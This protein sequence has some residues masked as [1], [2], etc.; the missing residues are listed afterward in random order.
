MATQ[1]FTID[2]YLDAL[3]RL[4]EYGGYEAL[5]GGLRE[6]FPSDGSITAFSASPLDGGYDEGFF[7]QNLPTSETGRTSG[8][9]SAER[10]TWTRY[11]YNQDPTNTTYEAMWPTLS[12]ITN[13][14]IGTPNV[15]IELAPQRFDSPTGGDLYQGKTDDTG[16]KEHK[17][18]PYEHLAYEQPT[19]GQ[20]GSMPAYYGSL[21]KQNEIANELEEL[22]KA[23]GTTPAQS[24]GVGTPT[25]P[26]AVTA[27]PAT[28]TPSFDLGAERYDITPAQTRVATLPPQ[29]IDPGMVGTEVIRPQQDPAGTI[30]DVSTLADESDLVPGRQIVARDVSNYVPEEPQ[31]KILD[32]ISIPIPPASATLPPVQVLPPQPVEV[33][34]TLPAVENRGPISLDIQPAIT[35]PSIAIDQI[36]LDD[37]PFTGISNDQIEL[38]D[39]IPVSEILSVP[40]NQIP[41]DPPAVDPAEAA[42]IDEIVRN[43]GIGALVNPQ[44]DAPIEP[45]PAPQ[46]VAQA[47]ARLGAPVVVAE[48]P[49]VANVANQ[50]EGLGDSVEEL[51][52]AQAGDPEY[53]SISSPQ[54]DVGSEGSAAPAGTWIDHQDNRFENPQLGYEKG[55]QFGTPGGSTDSDTEGAR[56]IAGILEEQQK[57]ND[58]GT[59]QVNLPSDP[60]VTDTVIPTDTTVTTDDLVLDKL[61]GE[62]IPLPTTTGPEGSKPTAGETDTNIK[63]TVTSKPL[64]EAVVPK[65][66]AETAEPVDISNVDTKPGADVD[67]DPPVGQGVG[68]ADSGKWGYART[69]NLLT[70]GGLPPEE[71]VGPRVPWQSMGKD[72]SS[73]RYLSNVGDRD[74]FPTDD[75]AASLI[76]EQPITGGGGGGEVVIPESEEPPY[77]AGINSEGTID[78]EEIIKDYANDNTTRT[79]DDLLGITTGERG[80][81]H[82][83]SLDDFKVWA[84]QPGMEGVFKYN[85]PVKDITGKET[86]IGNFSL[87]V[88]EAFL[89]NLQKLMNGV[90]NPKSEGVLI[91]GKVRGGTG[92][93]VLSDIPGITNEMTKLWETSR[94][95]P[96]GR[97]ISDPNNVQSY[98]NLHPYAIIHGLLNPPAGM[99]SF[100]NTILADVKNATKTMFKDVKFGDGMLT[101]GNTFQDILNVTFNVVGQGLKFI[102]KNAVGLLGD[103]VKA[104]FGGKDGSEIKVTDVRTAW[105]NAKINN[106]E[107]TAITEAFIAAGVPVS[108]F[109]DP[110]KFKMAIANRDKAAFNKIASE[111][112]LGQYSWKDI[113]A[114]IA[115]NEDILS[116]GMKDWL[117]ARVRALENM[118]K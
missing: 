33:L 110:M 57:E 26:T 46:P 68:W 99:I 20:A 11:L 65:G 28:R 30:E 115:G 83:R 58:T 7:F 93:S 19:T 104:F 43:A 45:P 77:N 103:K 97:S 63:A 1:Q 92:K 84:R 67:F 10:P 95:T 27:R 42:L 108:I 91:G 17:G 82:F 89:G 71:S 74:Y 25:A 94:D 36:A 100:A 52:A 29:V 14:N 50:Q 112:D 118:Q 60:N 101:D 18:D 73:T 56:L 49:L 15:G 39:D 109:S 31:V 5:A 47:G 38:I 48:E 59:T 55:T 88:Q 64:T 111:F 79:M 105:N 32:P 78:R 2:N 117:E 113:M 23:T 41:I 9:F 40:G 76:N 4:P 106:P 96:W 116:E 22:Q 75:Y 85:Y 70:G 62:E 72:A 21:D 8:P 87:D 13:P 53:L 16:G 66:T 86:K 37:A 90:G 69:R 107:I 6:D 44:I 80:V 54:G 102:G 51:I 35:D 114:G 12:R 81:K 61:E 24:S 34:D 3:T 98:G